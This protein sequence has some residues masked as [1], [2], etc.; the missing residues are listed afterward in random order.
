MPLCLTITSYHKIT[1]G[2]CFETTL[3]SGEMTIGR[4]LD[5]DWVL[6]DP[7]RLISSRHCVIKYMNGR[8]FVT[9]NSTNGVELQVAGI[10]LRR[11]NSEPLHEGEIIRIGDYEI[12]VHINTDVGLCEPALSEVSATQSFDALL[13]SSKYLSCLAPD[14]AH[15]A[16]VHNTVSDLFNFLT[17]AS[18]P[19]K[20]VS[21]HVPV[22][23][24]DFCPPAAPIPVSPQP[25]AATSRI[26]ADWD[27][28][29]G[30][31]TIADADPDQVINDP[32]PPLPS[33]PIDTQPAPV[34][35]DSIP[36]P[37]PDTRTGDPLQAFLRGAGVAH[38]RVDAAQLPGHMEMI[39]RSYRRMVEGLIDILR[40]RSS[41]KGEFRMQQTLIRPLE[42]NPL[43]F[44]PNADEA[45][46]LLLRQGNP[47][48]MD[49][50]QAI[51]DSFDDLRA[52]QLAVMAG[53]EASIQ[54]LLKRFEPARLEA[55]MASPGPLMQLFSSHSAQCWRR[56]TE[57]Y[58]DIS[59]EAE[60][61]FSELFGR[62][63]GRAYEQHSAR[64]REG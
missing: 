45:L 37:A 34:A 41:L 25:A 8:Y 14:P 24:H 19:P 39:G 17:P 54:A 3:K 35:K 4:G 36:G 28:L 33:D 27:F 56:F 23:R 31:S 1:P 29:G 55:R 48:F 42:N 26:P 2:Q 60:D 57:L 63:F 30:R 44:A 5:N 50:E 15:P 52:H 40:A 46:L 10:H 38:L 64:T 51:D 18:V 22:E 16:P 32:Q 58:E 11:G 43:K 13:A 9:D 61:D 49:P 21:D 62:E 59:K 12:S 7:A 53:V 20:T 6:A 47:A